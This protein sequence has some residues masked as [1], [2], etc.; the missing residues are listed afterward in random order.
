MDVWMQM[1]GFMKSFSDNVNTPTNDMKYVMERDKSLW[2]MLPQDNT[3][4]EE[5]AAKV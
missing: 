2:D 4:S 5:E 1:F 3:K